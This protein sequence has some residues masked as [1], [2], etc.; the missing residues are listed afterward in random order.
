VPLILEGTKDVTISGLRIMSAASR[1]SPVTLVGVNN[2][3]FNDCEL[4]GLEANGIE[5]HRGIRVSLAAALFQVVFMAHWS[6]SATASS[7]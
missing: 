5:I 3:E 2:I 1:K 7:S 4:V 6:S